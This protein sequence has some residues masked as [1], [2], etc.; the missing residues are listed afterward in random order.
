MEQHPVPQHIASFEFKLFGNLTVR[1]F[2]TLAIPMSLAA[3]IFFSGLPPVIRYPISGVIGLFAFFA[4]LVPINGRPLDKW[5]VSFI[6]AVMSPTL[7]IWVKEAKIPEFLL[8][9]TATSQKEEEI[10]ETITAQGRQRLQAYL[11]SLPKGN[12]SPLD[13]KEEIAVERLGLR[14]PQPLSQTSQ[15]GFSESGVLPPPII[16]PTTKFGSLPQILS[17][18]GLSMAQT[19]T[20]Q[21]LPSS[22]TTEDFEGVMEES[23]PP[24]IPTHKEASTK[25]AS[26]AKPYALPGLERKLQKKPPIEHVQLSPVAPLVKAQIASEANSAVENVISIRTPDRKIKLIHGIGRTRVRKLHF[27]P[28]IGFDLSKLPIRGEKRF[29]ISLEL[30]KRFSFDDERPPAPPVILP[31]SQPQSDSVQ[32]QNQIKQEPRVAFT[33]KDIPFIPKSNITHNATDVTL[34]KAEE[35]N[36]EA[37]ILVNRDQSPTTPL[38]QGSSK[39]QIFPLTNIPNVLSGIITD[40]EGNPLESAILIIK[41]ASGIPVR[42]LKTNKLGQFLSA[43]PLNDGPYTL[44]VESNVKTFDPMGLMLVGK[45]LEPLQIKSKN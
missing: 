38:P 36:L 20:G 28:P 40:Q 44:E 45:V 39:A 29:E 4:A 34:K 23:L 10:P 27:A 12:F 14:S 3:A 7:R 18:P 8:I 15:G 31:T 9:V 30:K 21:A 42:A 6:K 32:V 5:L 43:T 13:V 1:Q 41:E 22:Q 26:H 16:W 37:S 11:R 24:T 25:I 17:V 19:P 35:E 33:K 2:V